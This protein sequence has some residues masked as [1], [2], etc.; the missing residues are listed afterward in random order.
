MKKVADNVISFED[1]PLVAHKITRL[2]DINT[3]SKEVSELITELTVLMGYEAL[4]DLKT[5]LVEVEAPLITMDSPALAETFTI[6]PILRAGLGMVEGLKMLLPTARVGHVGLYRDQ[7]TLE[8]VKYY[9]KMPENVEDC[10]AIVCD[11]AFATGGSIDATIDFLKEDGFNRIKVMSIF[12]SDVGASRLLEHHPD[13][14]IYT[15]IYIPG[16]LNDAGFIVE[17]AGD[18]GDRLNGTYGYKGAKKAKP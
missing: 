18:I 10:P 17:A 5:E 13:V 4:K 12:T 7:K 8:P 1:H 2:R 6:I 15:A 3:G 11:P 16:G 14:D 9:Y